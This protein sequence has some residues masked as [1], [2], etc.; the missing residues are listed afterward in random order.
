M[1]KYW[2]SF[3]RIQSMYKKKKDFIIVFVSPKCAH[4]KLTNFIVGKNLKNER[5]KE[6]TKITIKEENL[7]HCISTNAP[8][9][10]FTHA[11]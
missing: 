5:K 6:K 1:R 4:E 11:C 2:L 10:S 9:T 8:H 3:A 7:T